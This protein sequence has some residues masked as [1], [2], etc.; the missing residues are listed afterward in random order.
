MYGLDFDQ[1]P[2]KVK[3]EN[4]LVDGK[5]IK[6]LNDKVSRKIFSLE[7][8]EWEN[9]VTDKIPVKILEKEPRSFRTP[10][11]EIMTAT[12][13]VA[14]IKIRARIKKTVE[15]CIK[16]EI[17]SEPLNNFDKA[18]LEACMTHQYHGRD[19][20]TMDTIY[21]YLGG[22]RQLGNMMRQE[23]ENSLDKL[24]LIDIKMDVT[25]A[26]LNLK[27]LQKPDG[28]PIREL[29]SLKRKTKIDYISEIEGEVR[30][31]KAFLTNYLLPASVLTIEFNGIKTTAVKFLDVSPLFLY[32]EDKGETLELQQKLLQP[33][34]LNNTQ[35]NIR[36]KNYILSRIESMLR[37]K[38]GGGK[39]L[40]EVITF[41]GIYNG[42]GNSLTVKTDRNFRKRVR[43]G[44]VKYLEFLKQE[45]KIKGFTPVNKEGKYLIDLA[46]CEKFLIQF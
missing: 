12:K 17:I 20:I 25:Q 39:N 8:E 6:I 11:G 33:P 24:R 4:I 30:E 28:S 37:S 29:K 42:S 34:K 35:I 44:A 41:K 2:I 7:K 10:G 23:I 36:M 16:Q 27:R 21:K 43:E 3:V 13:P 9:F 45:K 19:Y 5:N 46:K 32:A 18:V 14:E 31:P 40:V 22:T 38:R 26:Y 1:K 15:E